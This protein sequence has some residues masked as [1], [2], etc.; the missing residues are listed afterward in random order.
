MSALGPVWLKDLKRSWIWTLAPVTGWPLSVRVTVNP[1]SWPTC[2][3]SG[4][5]ANC[6]WTVP[7]FWT[8][9]SAFEP[10]QPASSRAANRR[11]LTRRIGDPPGS[12]CSQFAAGRADSWVLDGKSRRARLL[13]RKPV[14]GRAAFRSPVDQ[15]AHAAQ[16]LAE[17]LSGGGERD[18]DVLLVLSLVAGAE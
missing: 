4:T 7:A 18:A 11:A 12:R 15:C 8:R 17:Q 6:A 13:A 5:G 14:A 1:L 3:G 16:P 9:E 2:G 10:P